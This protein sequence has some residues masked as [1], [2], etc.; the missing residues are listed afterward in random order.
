M[1]RQVLERLNGLA[2][3]SEAADTVIVFLAI[4]LWYWVMAAILAFAAISLYPKLRGYLR[5]NVELVIF[6]V[7]AALLARYVVTEL[8]RFLYNRP[9]PFEI[10]DIHQLVN[11]AAGGSFPSGHAALSFAV[12]T[13][14]SFYYPKTSILFF[15]AAVLIGI[16]R[17]SAGVHWPSDILGGAAVGIGTAW[18]IRWI[19]QKFIK[20]GS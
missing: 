8:I 11:H 10:L 15:L 2:G 9:R 18:I 14:I 4:F 6:A 5:R 12:A 20:K 13:A 3:T 16:G 7:A 17:I 19:W 1:D